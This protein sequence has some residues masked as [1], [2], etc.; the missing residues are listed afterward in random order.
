MPRGSISFEL[1]GGSKATALSSNEFVMQFEPGE[2]MHVEAKCTFVKP[3]ALE[4]VQITLKW[5]IRQ[6]GIVKDEIVALK[7]DAPMSS[8]VDG[9][10][11]S[12]TFTMKLPDEPWSFQGEYFEI[13]WMVEVDTNQKR[14]LLGSHVSEAAAIWVRPST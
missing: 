2:E 1:H 12:G 9:K 5:S 14:W 3:V 4:H 8:S 11:H 10:S 6:Q 13:R 7:L